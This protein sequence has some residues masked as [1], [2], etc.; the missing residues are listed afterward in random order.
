MRSKHSEY[1]ITNGEWVMNKG[2]DTLCSYLAN[3]LDIRVSDERKNVIRFAGIVDYYIRNEYG[4]EY[5]SSKSVLGVV[6]GRAALD[7]WNRS[8]KV[9]P[10]DR[11]NMGSKYEYE[12]Y[13]SNLVNRV[14][15]DNGVVNK[16]PKDQ[17]KHN[18]MLITTSVHGSRVYCV[19]I[20]S[21]VYEYR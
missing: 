10:Y 18:V 16:L 5:S 8:F 4:Y 15:F 7:P 12:G 19:D 14:G 20:L 17:V 6:D 11:R 3:R 1:P 13:Y 2:G 9:F 21:G